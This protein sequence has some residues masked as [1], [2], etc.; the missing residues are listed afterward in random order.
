MVTACSLLENQFLTVVQLPKTVSDCDLIMPVFS[1]PAR[2]DTSLN[3]LPGMTAEMSRVIGRMHQLSAFMLTKDVLTAASLSSKAGMDW[4]TRIQQ[5][6]SEHPDILNKIGNNM[7]DLP[8]LAMAPELEWLTPMDHGDYASID[9]T[10]SFQALWLTGRAQLGVHGGTV[11]ILKQGEGDRDPTNAY[12]R[13]F[14]SEARKAG[15]TPTPAQ[16]PTGQFAIDGTCLNIPSR[17]PDRVRNLK[18]VPFE[19]VKPCDYEVPRVQI[20]VR[21]SWRSDI[22]V[23][24]PKV[25][26]PEPRS[27]FRPETPTSTRSSPPR[28]VTFDDGPQLPSISSKE[29]VTYSENIMEKM[30]AKKNI[31]TPPTRSPPRVLPLEQ[32]LA[33]EATGVKTKPVGANENIRREQWKEDWLAELPPMSTEDLEYVY[34]FAEKAKTARLLEIELAR[35]WVK[36][37]TSQGGHALLARVKVDID[38]TKLVLKQWAKENQVLYELCVYDSITFVKKMIDQKIANSQMPMQRHYQALLTNYLMQEKAESIID[39]K[40]FEV[41]ITETDNYKALSDGDNFDGDADSVSADLYDKIGNSRPWRKL[42]ESKGVNTH[43][44]MLGMA[45]PMAVA[46]L[47]KSVGDLNA[48]VV[49][50]DNLSGSRTDMQTY[51][52]TGEELEAARRI[53][54]PSTKTTSMGEDDVNDGDMF[55]VMWSLK[56]GKRYAEHSLVHKS[57][58]SRRMGPHMTRLKELYPFKSDM[59][60]DREWDN[61]NYRRSGYSE[62]EAQRIADE[63]RETF[64]I[65]KEE[66][67]VTDEAKDEE[68]RRS[69]RRNSEKIAARRRISGEPAMPWQ[70]AEEAQMAKVRSDA[71]AKAEAEEEEEDERDSDDDDDRDSDESDE[72]E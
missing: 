60:I 19:A 28:V 48:V 6:I 34:K 49:I 4:Y 69:M 12:I 56:T 53:D 63:V 20:P 25:N 8:V 10:S 24:K 29:S 59:K 58:K 44:V 15:V 9:E 70:T 62:Q 5:Y 13:H 17:R 18:V 27:V 41:P 23:Q 26:S 2:A 57:I 50:S 42:L 68:F 51:P 52:T 37:P 38:P 21:R 30:E 71:I 36:R 43:G 7:L 65:G 55:V 35:K 47:A 45:A 32:A 40:G 46:K 11:N 67:F 66:V 3:K 22:V 64:S 61:P 31:V 33:E 54:L 1:K 14:V 39:D 72:E 16:I